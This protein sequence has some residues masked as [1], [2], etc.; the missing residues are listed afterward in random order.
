VGNIVRVIEAVTRV[1]EGGCQEVA[2]EMIAPFGGV[3]LSSL[4]IGAVTQKRH[5]GS[6]TAPRP[7]IKT[8]G[9]I[10]RAVTR[11]IPPIVLI[12][13]RGRAES[14]T[15]VRRGRSAPRTAT[16]NRTPDPGTLDRRDP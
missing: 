3:A 11:E 4:E 7:K 1:R 13:G 16:R 5:K 6:Y 10:F 9:G 15:E 12:L 14:S 8:M 2:T